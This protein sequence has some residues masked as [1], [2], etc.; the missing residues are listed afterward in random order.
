MRVALAGMQPSLHTIPV[1]AYM[2]SISSCLTSSIC[3]SVRKSQKPSIMS[4]ASLVPAIT[5]SSVDSSC[6]RG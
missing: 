1:Q 5:R 4:T 2:H 6:K 3:S